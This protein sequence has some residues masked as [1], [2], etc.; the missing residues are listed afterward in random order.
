[1]ATSSPEK[2]RA[3]VL[4]LGVFA[5][6][7]LPRASQRVDDATHGKLS[8]AL[9]RG[10][11]GERAGASLLL[12][13]LPG[14]D[15]ERVLLVSLGRREGFG[16]KAFREALSGAA[17][18]LAASPAR[19]AADALADVEVPGRSAAWRLQ[20]ASRLLADGAY[21]FA[22]P[23][24]KTDQRKPARG[25]TKI[26]L[27]TSDR[28]NEQLTE[29]VRRGRRRRSLRRPRSV[30]AGGSGVDDSSSH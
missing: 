23:R 20:T 16:D 2:T 7:T 8:A 18:A 21:R 10:D 30:R 12:F 26:T 3:G 9:K 13:E 25:A 19:D 29:A 22:A 15:A 4:V 27:L 17:A 6:G 14:V 28:V 1:V 11:L 5:D 24:A